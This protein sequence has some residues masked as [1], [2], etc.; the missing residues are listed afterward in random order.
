MKKY[1]KRLFLYIPSAIVLLFLVVLGASLLKCEILTDKYYE[2]LE[3][4]HI[5]NTMIGKIN[6]FKVL[7]CDGDTAEVYY[8]CNDNTVSFVLNFEKQNNEWKEISWDCIWSKQ[9]SADE[10]IWPY[11]WHRLVYVDFII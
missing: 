7:K 11:W 2:E 3:C 5:E 8:V 1:I 4:A 10:M 6:S 9:G